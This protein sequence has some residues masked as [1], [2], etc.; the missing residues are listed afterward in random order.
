M[1]LVDPIERVSDGVRALFERSGLTSEADLARRADLPATVV[2][3]VLSG[4][5][6][7]LESTVACLRGL[8]ADLEDLLAALHELPVSLVAAAG[9]AVSPR[10]ELEHAPRPVDLLQD[11]SRLLAE[12][13]RLGSEQTPVLERTIT[14]IEQAVTCLARIV[15]SDTERLWAEA[16]ALSEAPSEEPISDQEFEQALRR[17]SSLVQ[18]STSEESARRRA[19]R[20]PDHRPADDGGGS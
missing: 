11:G 12:T 20:L 15:G 7:D 13:R 18:R 9:P 2:A 8:G 14:G 4:R 17:L 3:D 5:R 10:K 1:L 19:R 6:G 16:E